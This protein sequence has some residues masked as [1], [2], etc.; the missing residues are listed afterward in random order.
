[1]KKTALTLTFCLALLSAVAQPVRPVR[2]DG[3]R[4][5]RIRA[6]EQ[7]AA[8]A[9]PYQLTKMY[10]DD[11]YEVQRFS[12]DEHDRLLAVA[13]SI[14]ADIDSYFVIDSMHYNDKGQLVKY[15]GWQYFSGVPR[16]VYYIDYT[17]DERGDLVSRTNY[18]SFSGNFEL[19]GVY[20]YTYN[21][22]HQLLTSELTMS[23][24]VIQR[25]E[26]TYRDG[27]LLK[28]LWYGYDYEYERLY[29]N[30]VH[31]YGY[32][33][34]GQL[35]WERDSVS[36]DGTAWSF[37]GTDTYTYDAGGNCVLFEATDYTGE[38]SERSEYRYD[39]GIF[40]TDVAMPAYPEMER[41]KMYHNVNALSVESWWTLDVNHH[42]QYV[43]DYNYEYNGHAVS[44]RRAEGEP[45]LTAAPNPA[46][47][48][49]AIEGLAEQPQRM[50]LLDSAGRTVMAARVS[51]AANTI[52]VGP[53]PAGMYL[54]CV[55]GR[56]PVK[57]V[58]E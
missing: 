6:I 18:N 37:A 38:V 28:E 42:L 15:A 54:L 23:T 12:Y 35:A 14:N 39:L 36:D 27:K 13:D 24:G 11:G 57:L 4:L 51:A 40:L 44:I 47:G 52:D 45:A 20:T 55:D 48:R 56:Q 21:E 16:N 41:P 1:M 8:Q 5:N 33:N 26:R 22:N 7:M 32:D 58:V 3:H 19:G 17:Y 53:L 29:P 43:C 49:V 25:V 46:S 10:S 30:E 9:K 34:L 31:W 2:T 50:R